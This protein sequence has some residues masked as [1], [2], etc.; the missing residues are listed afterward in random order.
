M[1]KLSQLWSEWLCA[2]LLSEYQGAERAQ[3]DARGDAGQG[4]A[5]Q[6]APIKPALKPPGTKRLKL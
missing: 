4:E 6:V 5:V 1:L 3:A 2:A